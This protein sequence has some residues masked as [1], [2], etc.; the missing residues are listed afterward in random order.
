MSKLEHTEVGTQLQLTNPSQTHNF[1]WS[2]QKYVCMVAIIAFILPTINSKHS[3][4]CKFAA[5]SESTEEKQYKKCGNDSCQFSENYLAIH[6]TIRKDV[7][8][9]WIK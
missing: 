8:K 9:K 6:I 4:Y 3:S 5:V 1:R 7:Y 2:F